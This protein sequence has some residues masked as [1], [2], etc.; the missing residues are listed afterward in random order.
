VDIEDINEWRGITTK[1]TESLEYLEHGLMELEGKMRK[2]LADCQN[3]DDS[4]G[5]HLARAYLLLDMR[6]LGNLIDGVRR[7]KHG[8]GPSGT[9]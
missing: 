9:K 7:S 8:E 4:E 1:S 2:R 5:G 3:T 6:D